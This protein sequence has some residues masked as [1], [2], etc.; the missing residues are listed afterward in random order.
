MFED[1][2]KSKPKPEPYQPKGLVQ[3]PHCYSYNILKGNMLSKMDDTFELPMSCEAC[4]SI[5]LILYNEDMSY[6]C[7]KL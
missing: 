2:I 4:H 5:W 6:H 7:T 1:L 3:C